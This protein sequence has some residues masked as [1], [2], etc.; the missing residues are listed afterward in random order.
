M[1]GHRILSAWHYSYRWLVFSGVII[2]GIANTACAGNWSVLSRYWQPYHPY[3]ATGEWGCNDCLQPWQPIRS[4]MHPNV[5]PEGMWRPL[6][7]RRPTPTLA[8]PTPLMCS[9]AFSPGWHRLFLGH[10]R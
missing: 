9:P 10:G 7:L 8:P 3:G 2:F 4:V 6:P 1:I 5:L